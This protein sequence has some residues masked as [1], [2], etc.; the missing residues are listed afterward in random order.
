MRSRTILEGHCLPMLEKIKESV[1]EENFQKIK[2]D[3]QTLT[4]AYPATMKHQRLS[5]MR[6]ALVK[7]W[8]QTELQEA[9]Q[10]ILTLAFKHASPDEKCELLLVAVQENVSTRTQGLLNFMVID[11]Q[12]PL[13]FG[14]SATWAPQTFQDPFESIENYEDIFH[15]IL[16]YGCYI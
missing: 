8:G 1:R 13:Q 14:P 12:C 6:R 16:I 9:H 15:T 5:E 3:L 4:P 2:Q 11:L 7:G 10:E